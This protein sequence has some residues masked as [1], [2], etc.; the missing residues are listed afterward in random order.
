MN[1]ILRWCKDRW[2]PT[3]T[4]EKWIAFTVTLWNGLGHPMKR[5]TGGK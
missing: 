1:Q 4:Q 5:G 3:P 2:I